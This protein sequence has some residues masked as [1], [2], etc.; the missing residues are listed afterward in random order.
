VGEFKL[1][2]ADNGLGGLCKNLNA[3]NFWKALVT[4]LYG[5]V[6]EVETEDGKETV[7][8]PNRSAEKYANLL[9]Y[10]AETGVDKDK[11]V[12]SIQTF[13]DPEFGGGLIGMEKRDRKRNPGAK[14]KAASIPTD[15]SCR[16][17]MKRARLIKRAENADLN[18]DVFAASKPPRSLTY[19]QAVYKV[20]D[21]EMVIVGFKPW[22]Q[23]EYENYLIRRARDVLKQEEEL[24]A[25]EDA[26]QAAL[27]ADALNAM[28]GDGQQDEVAA[29]IQA[30]VPKDAVQQAIAKAIAAM[31][32]SAD[33][34][35]ADPV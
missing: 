23:A 19:G 26:R 13:N 33:L 21:G 29:L 31:R 30:G 18:D 11:V 14:P 2:L 10:L 25:L 17:Q 22:S 7:C 32:V 35:E 15:P 8:E 9:R 16:Q 27:N 6:H 1:V 4:L 5:N 24:Q 12:E 34:I 28:T 3:K 20:H